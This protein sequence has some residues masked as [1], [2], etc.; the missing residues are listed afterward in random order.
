MEGKTFAPQAPR[1]LRRTDGAYKMGF[2]GPCLAERARTRR[3][4][5]SARCALAL[6]LL[7]E[8]A[9][10]KACRLEINVERSP[11]P[12]F[13]VLFRFCKHILVS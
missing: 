9:A 6:A 8:N 10:V 2:E 3:G 12:V 13:I 1:Y 4:V 11:V 7:R 5:A